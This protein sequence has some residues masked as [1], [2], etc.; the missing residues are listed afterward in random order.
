MLKSGI[1]ACLLVS[2]LLIPACRKNLSQNGNSASPPPLIPALTK[3]RMGEAPAGLLGSRA[4]S[5]VHWQPWDP[6]ALAHATE[7]NRLVFAFIGSARYPSSV[8]AL[9][10]IDKDSALAA[11]LNAELSRVSATTA[12]AWPPPCSARRSGP[13]S[14]SRSPFSFRPRAMK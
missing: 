1:R 3:N 8:E 5:P 2:L 10:L 11:R 13:R 6:A 14:P 12:Q 4:A 9:D 7:A